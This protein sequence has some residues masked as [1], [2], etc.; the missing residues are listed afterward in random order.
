M[1][2]D[3]EK[4]KLRSVYGDVLFSE[5]IYNNHDKIIPNSLK[6]L[7]ECLVAK[8]ARE[9]LLFL[10]GGSFKTVVEYLFKFK[11][12]RELTIFTA[13]SDKT[14]VKICHLL[15][16]ITYNDNTTIFKK[17]DEASRF[18]I[19]QLGKVRLTFN[20]NF[21]SE[22]GT[23]EYFGERGL[24]FQDPRLATAVSIGNTELYYL[25][26]KDFLRLFVDN[27][28]LREHMGNRINLQDGN[29]KIEDLNVVSHISDGNYGEVVLGQNKNNN[30]L[31]ALKIMY[32]KKLVE[33]N[34]VKHLKHEKQVLTKLDHP[35]V[36]KLSK[37]LNHSNFIIFVMEYINGKNLFDVLGDLGLLNM[38]QAR[39]FT[40]CLLIGISK[41][42]EQRMLFRDL[43][44]DNVM[45][46]FNGFLKIIDFGYAITMQSN[47]RTKTLIGT[48]H[49]MAPEIFFDMSGYSFSVDY[50]AIGNIN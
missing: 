2:Q 26:R 13:L 10:L 18:Y 39:F 50:W 37:S 28:T 12:C 21:V 3:I 27:P 47:D 8:I 16:K 7:P 1:F 17:N 11:F 43:K 34:I 4:K 35:F 20:D 48:P 32:K 45:V 22:L 5:N 15:H 33:E 24:F 23:G 30:V 29:L 19:I 6:A 49:Y 46:N 25:D 42:H 41:I 9:S 36:I 14:L 44:P 31:Y 40:A 38:D